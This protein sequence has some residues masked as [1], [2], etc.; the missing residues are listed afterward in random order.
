MVGCGNSAELDQ[1]KSENSSLQK[2]VTQ[3]KAD[4]KNLEDKIAM[5]VPS[6]LKGKP[7]TDLPDQP[8][9]VGNFSIGPDDI[10]ITRTRIELIN[11][12]SKTIDAA[13][14]V[15]LKF[16]N[17]GRPAI[18]Q[19]DGNITSPLTLQ[20]EAASNGVLSGA[21]T[22]YLSDR[23]TKGKIILKQVHFT[24]GSVWRNSQFQEQVDKEK[25]SYN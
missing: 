2:E 9:K 8:M 14:F 25:G 20:G 4:K 7:V 5:Y 3:L 15:I 17:F 23:A 1:L 16:D 10:G 24:D 12:T 22:L 13:E 11:V 21:W 18:S 6:E 19:G